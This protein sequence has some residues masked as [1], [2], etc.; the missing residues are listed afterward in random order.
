MQ[1]VYIEYL[2]NVCPTLD[3]AVNKDPICN[4]NIYVQNDQFESNA[5]NA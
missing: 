5:Y 4:K 1:Y 3:T 2:E